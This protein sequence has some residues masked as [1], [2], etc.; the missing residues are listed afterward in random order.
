MIP[1]AVASLAGV[2]AVVF[3]DA[4]IGLERAGVAGIS[5][6]ESGVISAVNEAARAVGAQ[7]GMALRAMLEKL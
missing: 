1:A 7:K 4:E 5:A 3:N 2:R 6:L